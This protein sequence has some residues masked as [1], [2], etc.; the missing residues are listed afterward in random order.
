MVCSRSVSEF[1]YLSLMGKLR[2]VQ[3]II[4]PALE[5][6][7]MGARA[8]GR[9]RSLNHLRGKTSILPS[10]LDSSCIWEAERSR[11]LLERLEWFERNHSV[12]RTS[13]LDFGIKLHVSDGVS[14]VAGDYWIDDEFQLA[15]LVR[16]SSVE[17]DAYSEIVDLVRG[18]LGL[19]GLVLEQCSSGQPKVRL[20]FPCGFAEMRGLTECLV[21]RSGELPDDIHWLSTGRCNQDVLEGKAPFEVAENY[22]VMPGDRCRGV[23]EFAWGVVFDAAIELGCKL[24]C[25]PGWWTYNVSF[26]DSDAIARCGVD[27]AETVLFDQPEARTIGVLSTSFGDIQLNQLYAD[28]KYRLELESKYPLDELP[29]ELADW[30]V[31]FDLK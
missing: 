4:D 30:G 19:P 5:V 28:G 18:L 17:K 23:H 31:E 10:H 8:E 29:K 6:R 7:A 13:P 26:T 2:F 11:G 1:D 25:P 24:E 9:V 16:A 27:R 15:I 12:I 22:S 14:I 3:D 20:A 21:T